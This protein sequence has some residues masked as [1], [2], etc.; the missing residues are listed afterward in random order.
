MKITISQPCEANALFGPN[1][2]KNAIGTTIPFHGPT[3]VV[4]AKVLG[5][6][7]AADGKS[8]ELTLDVPVDLSPLTT[9][10]SE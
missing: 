4:D 1:A 7:V 2:F 9:K 3:G 6:S 10:E 5:A 8:V